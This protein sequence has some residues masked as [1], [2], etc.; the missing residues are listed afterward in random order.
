M[1]RQ[2]SAVAQ[3]PRYPAAVLGVAGHPWPGSTGH[4]PAGAFAPPDAASQAPARWMALLGVFW[5]VLLAAP[6][7]AA[8][9][10]VDPLAGNDANDGQTAVPD[11]PDGPH[12]P[13]ATL[14][15]A[16]DTAAPGDTVVALPGTYPETVRCRS[17]DLLITSL[18]PADPAVV[19]TTVIGGDP[20]A[21]ERVAVLF[22]SGAGRRAVL[23]GFTLATGTGRGLVCRSGSSP[24]LRRLVIRGNGG[25]AVAPGGGILCVESDA[26]IVNTLVCQ[27]SS[28]LG[29]G[30]VELVRSCPTLIGCTIGGN[31]GLGAAAPAGGGLAC[32]DSDPALCHCILW[33]NTDSAWPAAPQLVCTGLSFPSVSYSCVQGGQPAGAPDV[34]WG[35]GNLEVDPRFADAAYGDFRLQSTGGRWDGTHWLADSLTSPCIDAGDPAADCAAEPAP[36]GGRVNLGFDGNTPFAS[37]SP[38]APCT[39]VL[40]PTGLEVPEGGT[41]AFTVALSRAPD[42][43][44]SVVVVP[45]SAP[46]AVALA[47]SASFTLDAGNWVAGESVVLSSPEDDTDTANGEAVV[48]VEATGIAAAELVVRQLDDDV[49]LAVTDAEPAGTTTHERGALVRVAATPQPGWHFR[50]WEGD[51]PRERSFDNPLALVMDRARTVRAV[52]TRNRGT[53]WTT[54]TVNQPIWPGAAYEWVEGRWDCQGGWASDLSIV[55]P[56]AAPLQHLAFLK[57]W[58]RDT[59]RRVVGG[60][61][62]ADPPG[63]EPADWVRKPDWPTE[64]CR[65][66]SAPPLY[67]GCTHSLRLTADPA[68]YQG[69]YAPRTALPDDCVVQL[70]L[71]LPETVP[72]DAVLTQIWHNGVCVALRT[73]VDGQPRVVVCQGNAAQPITL[74]QPL[75]LG[76]WNLL[77]IFQWSCYDTDNDGLDDGWEKL[78]LTGA[79][80]SPEADPDGDGLSNLEEYRQGTAATVADTDGDGLPDGWEV[81]VALD[82]WTDDAGTDAD[83]DGLT[84]SW[85]RRL[86]THP[87]A[88]DVPVALLRAVHDLRAFWDLGDDLAAPP[89][90]AESTAADPTSAAVH[91]ARLELTASSGRELTGLP[92][93]AA[94][95][96]P[97]TLSLWLRTDRGGTVLTAWAATSGTPDLLLATDAAGGLTAALTGLGMDGETSTWTG[98]G[99]AALQVWHHL[100]IVCAEAGDP[101]LFVDGSLVPAASPTGASITP[102]DWCRVWLG[103]APGNP[104][105]SN[106]LTGQLTGLAWFGT[107]LSCAAVRQLA[108]AGPDLNLTA[109]QQLDTDAN[110]LPD[111][112][113]YACFG[114]LDSDPQEDPDQ[115]ALANAD[116]FERSCD[117]LNPDSDGDDLTDGAES[118]RH[119][120]NP[121]D[122]DSDDDG[123]NDGAEAAAGTDPLKADSDGD[124]LPDGWEPAYG[125]SPIAADSNGDGIADAV[126]DRDGDGLTNLEEMQAGTNPVS[127]D[128]GESTVSFASSSTNTREGDAMLS[129]ELT[130]SHLP[131]WRDTVDLLVTCDGGTATPGTDFDFSETPVSFAG[132]RVTATVA[133]HLRSD[134]VREPTETIVLAIHD[135]RGARLGANATHT[136]SLADALSP[137]DDTDGDGLPDD[138]EMRFFGNLAQSAADDADHDGLPNLEE[139]RIGARPDRGFQLVSPEQLKLRVTGLSR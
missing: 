61:F 114:H 14:Q 5:L 75:A 115:D 64:R 16:I 51:V 83:G 90:D 109:L 32:E 29:P 44:V 136:V 23:D 94:A 25:T 65:V 40:I 104:A 134:T 128:V 73:G 69:L 121:L 85:E 77:T 53:Y 18:D 15:A 138:W 12:G 97:R 132:G 21:D 46:A 1:G 125:L 96:L 107:A 78:A 45:P 33:G 129:L 31:T 43:P 87:R 80:R 95:A 91:D 133:V 10:Y 38:G 11:G 52:F 81:E 88:A 57:A 30:G 124:G 86:G 55:L 9:W 118:W 113:E 70:A 7:P 13:K 111:A 122:P 47:S 49:T 24:T 116:E 68:A 72:P 6:V 67:P 137:A 101:A 100:A 66:S 4:W 92:A 56:P 135:A 120:T 19:A 36:N 99:A 20:A 103:L 27:N 2:R 131:P 84:N 60:D 139:Y 62:E 59:P 126:A 8:T 119:G 117:P 130:L 108:Q 112:W 123:L 3:G 35:A 28:L 39:F 58:P 37:R 76:R 79:G 74:N 127:P 26:L 54:V 50:G 34:T 93:G 98:E 71:H 48:R 102:G 106:G 63:A 105:A 82:P 17:T 42:A 89:G 41:A 110:R 22:E